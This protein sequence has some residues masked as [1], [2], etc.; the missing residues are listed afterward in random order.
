M[1]GYNLFKLSGQHTYL[2][3]LSQCDEI[4]LM[5][6][7]LNVYILLMQ[8]DKTPSKCHFD[9]LFM[10]QVVLPLHY[11]DGRLL[12]FAFFPVSC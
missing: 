10:P 4:P 12:A 6:Y 1:Q 9:E 3:I 8:H 7:I 2:P 5:T 11:L